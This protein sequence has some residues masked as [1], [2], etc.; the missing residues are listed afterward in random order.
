MKYPLAQGYGMS[1]LSAA[2]SF[3]VGD[4][5]KPRSV[6]I[7]SVTT[8]VGIFDRDTGE[9]LGYN[10]RGEICVTGPS[11]MKSYFN[12][13]EETAHVMRVHEDG[14]TWIHSG[15]IGYIDEDGFLFVIGR[16]K[17]RPS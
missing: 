15:D 1:E 16:M 17:P 3:C 9:E 13:P 10:Q 11:M 6:G 5:H 12:A 2:A 14:K 7:P 8:T 4:I